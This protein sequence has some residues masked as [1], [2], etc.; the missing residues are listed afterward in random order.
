MVTAFIVLN[1]TQAVLN[2]GNDAGTTFISIFICFY[3][4]LEV[5]LLFS[6]FKLNK[7]KMVFGII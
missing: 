5:I 7:G 1:K 3:T 2:L 4:R 6:A